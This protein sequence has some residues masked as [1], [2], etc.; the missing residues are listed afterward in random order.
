MSLELTFKNI[1]RHTLLC[2]T[3]SMAGQAL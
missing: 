2:I 1:N 3:R